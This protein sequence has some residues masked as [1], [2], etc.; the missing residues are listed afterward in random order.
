M[1]KADD[2]Y[3][4]D[5]GDVSN[6]VKHSDVILSKEVQ[7]ISFHT[8][9]CIDVDSNIW[10]MLVNKDNSQLNIILL[11]DIFNDFSR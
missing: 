9:K 5:G 2:N 6:L 3:F 7:C 1:K 10:V 11:S 8:N 4:A